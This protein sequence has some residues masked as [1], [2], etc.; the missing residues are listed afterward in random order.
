MREPRPRN[1]PGF[2]ESDE[3]GS[4]KTDVIG[5]DLLALFIGSG[6]ESAAGKVV[7]FAQ[8]AGGTLLDGSDGGGAEE[9]GFHPG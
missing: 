1:G 2:S 8:E 5:R 9:L 4:S 6:D 7:G 3:F